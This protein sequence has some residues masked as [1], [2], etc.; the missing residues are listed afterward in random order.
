MA[1][2][3]DRY[4]TSDLGKVGGGVWEHVRAVGCVVRL[5]LL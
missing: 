2:F 1:G 4:Y 5:M 3:R